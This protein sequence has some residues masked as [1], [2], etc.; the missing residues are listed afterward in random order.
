MDP[1]L[2][3][4]A[5][6]LG[7]A[8]RN[9]FWL[10]TFPLSLPGVAAGVLLCFIPIVGEFVIPDLLAGSDSLMIGQTLWLEFFTNKD[11]PV[12]SAAAVLL[13]ALLLLPLAFYDR[14]QRRQLEGGR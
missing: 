12:A 3:E 10:V 13:L 5:G 7:A 11:W 6:D 1:A 4:A 14:L 2:L 9:A 8:P